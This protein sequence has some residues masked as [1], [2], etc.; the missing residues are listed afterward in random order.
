MTEI[1]ERL[2]NK[3]IAFL[4]LSKQGEVILVD[5]YLSSKYNLQPKSKH[6]KQIN[7]QRILLPI[8]CL[9]T[10]ANGE[11]QFSHGCGTGAP[12]SQ[13]KLDYICEHLG[14]NDKITLNGESSAC[15]HKPYARHNG[16]KWKCYGSLSKTKTFGCIND[17]SSFI[18]CFT[19][20]GST[21]DS[22]LLNQY[23]ET[24]ENTVVPEFKCSQQNWEHEAWTDD[25]EQPQLVLNNLNTYSNIV[26]SSTLPHDMQ[27]ILSTSAIPDFTNSYTI[28]IG[29]NG[30]T[31]SCVRPAHPSQY[32]NYCT[33]ADSQNYGIMYSEQDYLNTIRHHVQIVVTE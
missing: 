13:Q 1:L 32:L 28:V 16:V 3:L 15:N 24:I 25:D 27:F 20:A 22:E 11:T 31:T 2:V 10:L 29:G 26:I 5:N 8:L 33:A 7:M 19:G 6:E 17:D 12:C 21:C 4:F 14:S 18:S 9:L 30:G 23:S